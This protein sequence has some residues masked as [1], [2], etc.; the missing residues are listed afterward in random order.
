[1]KKSGD[2]IVDLH[3]ETTLFDT[4]TYLSSLIS[5]L[6]CTVFIFI[7]AAKLKYKE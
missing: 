5:L 3:V 6:I 7:F 2:D 1:M 4:S